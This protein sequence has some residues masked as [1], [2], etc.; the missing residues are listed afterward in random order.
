MSEKIE[1]DG[2]EKEVFTAEE[3][4]AQTK[5]AAEAEATRVAAEK[6]AEIERLKKVSAEK[7][8]NFRKYNEMTQE[9]RDAHSANELELI[10]RNDKIE[11]E[12]IAEREA[13]LAKEKTENERTKNNALKGFH[14]DVAEVKEKIEKSYAALAG[15]P[16]TTPE[17]VQARAE[18]AARLAGI[19][20]ES[21]NPIHQSFSGEAPRY[22]EKSE[23]V[24]TPEG[25]EAVTL[26]RQALG[27]AEPKK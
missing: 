2:V 19:S 25:Q 20:V 16:E 26:A 5:A 1:I 10:K 3:V 18:A 7:T 24:E 6:D 8:E 12:L 15:M 14:A 23:Y 21:R 9:E 17:E 4:A 11:A 27:V 22:K 13:R